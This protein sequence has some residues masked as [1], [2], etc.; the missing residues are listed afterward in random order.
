MKIV[1]NVQRRPRAHI[2]R[3]VGSPYLSA[4]W[5]IANLANDPIIKRRHGGI[6]DRQLSTDSPVGRGSTSEVVTNHHIVGIDRLAS[7][8]REDAR[9]I[10]TATAY[11]KII[12]VNGLGVGISRG[13][14]GRVKNNSSCSE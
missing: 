7:T 12:H 13:S 5:S 11:S 10:G 8:Q 9:I 6:L 4:V 1:S 2:D 14:A 3:A